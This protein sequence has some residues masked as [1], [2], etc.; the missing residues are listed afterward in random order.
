MTE[1]E[2]DPRI[3]RPHS[4]LLI[5]PDKKTYVRA[6]NWLLIVS[7]IIV[8]IREDVVKIKAGITRTDLIWTIQREGVYDFKIIEIDNFEVIDP[9]S[10]EERMNDILDVIHTSGYD[11]V[12]I[13][14]R[15]FLR[16]L[17]S[18]EI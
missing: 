5:F 9:R 8:P 4:F 16:G 15:L 3:E 17:S 13:E 7:D 1:P 11:F 14:D 12:P 2:L 10:D 18:K 6:L